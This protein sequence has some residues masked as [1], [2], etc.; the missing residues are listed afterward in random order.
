MKPLIHWIT[1][2]T[3]F[4]FILLWW[5]WTKILT[6]DVSAEWGVFVNDA[7]TKVPLRCSPLLTGFTWLHTRASKGAPVPIAMD[8]PGTDQS[9]REKLPQLWSSSIQHSPVKCCPSWGWCL[10]SLSCSLPLK[11]CDV[12]TVLQLILLVAWLHLLS[13]WNDKLGCHLSQALYQTCGP[14]PAL[15]FMV[16][17]RGRKCVWWMCCSLHCSC[18]FSFFVALGSGPHYLVLLRH[19]ASPFPQIT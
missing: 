9:C 2:K 10:G 18:S 15:G 16:S 6:Q 13:F 1:R 8:I 14:P 19:A 5:I 3:F 4:L 7:C 12:V 17:C 11:D